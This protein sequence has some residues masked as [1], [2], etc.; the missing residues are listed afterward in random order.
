MHAA[1]RL[2][3]LFWTPRQVP[4]GLDGAVFDVPN[5]GGQRAI[6]A[7]VDRKGNAG[8]GS[9]SDEREGLA[10]RRVTDVCAVS[11]DHLISVVVKDHFTAAL[12]LPGTVKIQ[13]DLPLL[14]ERFEALVVDV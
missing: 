7:E 14:K 2:R 8:L 10:M 1:P 6:A 11:T 13:D 5:P 3:R 9:K 4:Q 12:V